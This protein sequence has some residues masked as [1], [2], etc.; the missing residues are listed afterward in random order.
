M[1]VR[2]WWAVLVVGV[3]ALAVLLALVPEE[4]H[5]GDN[6]PV[7]RVA[8]LRETPAVTFKVSGTYEI[9]NRATG[10]LIAVPRS[11]ET[12]EVRPAGGVLQVTRNG[13]VEG[14]FHGPIMVRES[15]R[16]I[17]FQGAGQVRSE[18]PVQGA[19]LLA[20]GGRITTLPQDVESV[21]VADA[22]GIHNVTVAGERGVLSVQVDG[23]LRKYRG[24]LE[25][26]SGRR[27]EDS[28]RDGQGEFLLAVNELGVEDYL[29]GVV[30]AEMPSTWPQEALRAQAVAARTCALWHLQNPVHDQYHVCRSQATQVYRGLD[31]ERP[32]SNQAVAATRGQVMLYNGQPIAAFYHSSS[33]GYTE[34]VEDVWREPLPYIR[35]KTDPFDRND[36]HYNWRVSYNA[37]Q[38]ANQLASR[39]YP[40]LSVT[41]IEVL[42]TTASG[43]RVQKLRVSGTGLDFQPRTEIIANADRVRTALGL[44]SALF[45]LE[46]EVD[47]A[48]GNLKRANIV[49]HGWGHGLGMSQYGAR[50]M[51][52]EGFNYR[53]ILHH[54]YTGI[55]IRPNYGR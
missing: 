5:A 10:G 13:E 34:N 38:L 11:G 18:R 21:V 51:A 45:E 39:Q 12:W 8:L 41:D 16:A 29:Y 23:A 24:Q 15:G 28:Q 50:G 22:R 37:K 27:A 33:G 26:I 53:E 46:K 35:G 42:A 9:V 31:W 25:I 19:V 40:F 52:Q 3:M 20:A 32:A 36:R 54:Y 7:I 48:T 44:K 43:M 17:T 30:P 1:A 47:P 14:F 6:E 4:L 55:S 49:G 2:Y